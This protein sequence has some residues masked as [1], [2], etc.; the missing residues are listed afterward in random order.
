MG[1]GGVKGRGEISTLEEKIAQTLKRVGQREA[2][3]SAVKRGR[4]ARAD[5]LEHLPGGAGFRDLVRQTKARCID[6]LDAL[7]TRFTQNAQARGARVYF[8]ET[9][10]DA[11]S[12]IL[13]L[14]RDRNAR[15]IAKSK[16]LTTEEIE[17]NRPLEEAGLRVVETDL[18]ERII[19]LAKELPYHLVFPAVHKRA[20]EVA[21]LFGRETGEEVGDDLDDIM[22]LIRRSLR[23]VFMNADIGIT[24]ANVAIAETGTV[25]IETNEGNGRLVSSIPPVHVCVMGIEKLVDTVE[26][27]LQMILAHP[28]S[29]VG[30][31]LTTYVSFFAGRAPLGAQ[32]QRELHIVVLDNGRRQMRA[33]APLREALH[34]IRCGACMNI[35]PTYGVLGGH[36]FGHIYPGPIGIPWTA[37]VHGMEAAARFSDLCISCGLCQEICPAEIDLP[38]MIAEVKHRALA[39]KSQPRANRVLMRSESFAKLACATAPVSNWLLRRKVARQMAEKVLGIDRRRTLPEFTRR[40]LLSRVKGRVFPARGQRRGRV[41]YF[42]DYHA[43]FI[44][45]EL[46]LAATGLIQAAGFDVVFPGQKTSG[47][48]YISYGELDRARRIASFNLERIYPLIAAGARLVAT[49]PTAIYAFKHVYPKLLPDSEEA[50]RVAERAVGLFE[51]LVEAGDEEQLGLKPCEDTR[52]FGLHLSCH[53]RGEAGATA[54]LAVLRRMGLAVRLIETGTCCGM[55][56]TFGLKSGPLGY[57]LSTAVAEPLCRLFLES[58]VDVILSESSV[59]KMQLAEGTGRPVLHPL[60]VLVPAGT[61]G[62]TS[63]C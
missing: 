56:G 11:I 48:P 45:P 13:Q 33:D 38:M 29:A 9:G 58:G 30:Q 7:L 44:S 2:L 63:W 15:V 16:S 55:G 17:L 19:Q 35:C 14:A 46:G 18:G 6:R 1:D 10:Q 52:K 39:L 53:Q 22:H 21:E 54:A 27:A 28:V 3:L 20:A 59:C 49:E 26:D 12:Y 42:V 60:E 50:K 43:N 47:Y 24:G 5:A 62:E 31:L 36:V 57:D 4:E 40:P 34:C 37:E 61:M 51:F 41:V 25:L 8:A 32:Q 23:P